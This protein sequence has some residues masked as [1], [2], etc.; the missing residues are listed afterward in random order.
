MKTKTWL[1]SMLSCIAV[2]SVSAQNIPSHDAYVKLYDDNVSQNF[3]DYFRTWEPGQALSEDENFFISRVPLK[4]R[5][6]NANTQ[7]DPTLT[8]DRKF[9]MWTPM[10]VADTYWQSLPR[11]VFDGDN[12]SMWSYV[13]SQGGWSLP[14][15]RVPGAYSDVTHRN[16]VANSGG[17]IFFDSWGGDNTNAN[18]CVRMLTEKENGKF[19][20]AEKL[21]KFMRY[22]GVDG[23][24]VNPEGSVPNASDF[25]DFI[26]EC[27][28][29][30]KDLNWQFHIYWYGTSSNNGNMDLEIG[31]ASCRERV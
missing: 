19:K 31:R 21:V 13:D 12:F 18:N 9:C 16:G 30:A 7:V 25:Q 10:G 3:Y 22:Y 8:T 17:L 5:F 27:R 20:Y 15:I 26:I 29:I 11:Y 28:K 23:L 1:F 24:G 4:K 2:S 14:W 6:E